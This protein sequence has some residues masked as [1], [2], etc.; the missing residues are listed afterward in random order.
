MG[1]ALKNL[2]SL[3]VILLVLAALWVLGSRYQRFWSAPVN[4]GPNL[5]SERLG[6]AGE[7]SGPLPA[8]LEG[9]FKSLALSLESDPDRREI[10]QGRPVAPE[11]ALDLSSGYQGW[12]EYLQTPDPTRKKQLSVRAYDGLLR[13]LAVFVGLLFLSSL[14]VVAVLLGRSAASVEGQPGQTSLNLVIAV[15]CA[16]LVLPHLLSRLSSVVWP[17]L[18]PFPR[19]ILAQMGNYLVAALLLA[20]FWRWKEWKP[21]RAVDWNLVGKCYLALLVI[22]PLGEVLLNR[23]TGLAPNVLLSLAPVFQ[24]RSVPEGALLTI[25]AVFLGPLVEELMF[26]GWLLLGLAQHS[27]KSVAL[28][29]SSVLFALCH[30]NLGGFPILFAFGLLTG[31]MT[32]RTGTL[33]SSLALHILW[34][35]TTLCLVAA[36]V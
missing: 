1:G 11:R 17:T 10:L 29:V 14:G 16:W 35:A 2:P 13:L 26:R 7:F 34:N 12:S 23:L 20:A 8:G 3:A 15:F 18:D 31:W 21:W 30:G 33:A 36:A 5:L 22:L 25:I 27:K 32:L 28:L 24:G 6:L 9:G 4:T 19:M